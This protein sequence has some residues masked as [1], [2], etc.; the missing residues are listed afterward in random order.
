MYKIV[1]KANKENSA[2]NTTTT[3]AKINPIG[4]IKPKPERAPVIVVSELQR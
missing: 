2:V 1:W 4:A 3:S